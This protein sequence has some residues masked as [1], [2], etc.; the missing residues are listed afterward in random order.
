M[1]EA[2]DYIIFIIHKGPF[3]LVHNPRSWF[4]VCKFYTTTGPGD[5]SWIYKAVPQLRKASQVARVLS[6]LWS[7]RPSFC[8]DLQ[9]SHGTGSLK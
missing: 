8:P 7:E 4:M 5:S 1:E 2:V 3:E 9:I 6:F